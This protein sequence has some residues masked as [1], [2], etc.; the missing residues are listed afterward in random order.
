MNFYSTY[1]MDTY[2]ISSCSLAFRFY[3]AFMCREIQFCMIIARN[4]P[5]NL[6]FVISKDRELSIWK[7]LSFPTEQIL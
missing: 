1:K 6:I 2:D 4:I 5:T 7:A 3:R